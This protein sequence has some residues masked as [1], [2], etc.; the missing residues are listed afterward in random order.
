SCG[1]DSIC[2][3]GTCTAQCSNSSEDP[4]CPEGSSCFISGSGALNL[5]LFGCDPLLQDCDDGEGCY[6]YGDD[7][8]CNPT[9]EDIPTGGPCSL[10]NDCAIDNVCVDALYLPSCDGPACCATWCDLGDPVCAVPGTECV[11]WYEQGTAPSGYENVG[12]C[13]LPG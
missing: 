13:V 11:A 12:V 6:W 3:D 9:G 1:A 10:I 8:Q 4:I 2:W 7:F 5:C